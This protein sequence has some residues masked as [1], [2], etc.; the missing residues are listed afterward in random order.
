MYWIPASEP[1]TG[2][3]VSM[4]FY[5]WEILSMTILNLYGS[6][7]KKVGS[8]DVERMLEQLENREGLQNSFDPFKSL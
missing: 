8:E 1:G 6:S 7:Y 2:H 5:T 3:G 4:F